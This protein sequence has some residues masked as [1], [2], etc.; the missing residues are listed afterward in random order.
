M[1]EN[2]EFSEKKDSIDLVIKGGTLL[3][4]VDGKVP[5]HAPWILIRDNRIIDILESSPEFPIPS[6]TEIIDAADSIILPG[7]I[8]AHSHT[9]MT[10]F[11]G[12]SDDLPLAQWLFD[13]IFPAEAK[14]L[15]PDSVYYGTLLGCLEMIA[16]GTTSVIDGYFFQ[17]STVKAFHKAGLRGLLAQ[18][19]IDFSAPGVE[20]PEKNLEIGRAFLDR[21][22]D[23]SSLITPGLF[24]HSTTT[25][26]EHT[27]KN[28]KD[29]CDDY[30]IP[31]Q[32]HLSETIQD[33]EQIREKTGLFPVNYLD[34][35]GIL[36]NQL[37]AVHSVHLNDEEIDIL[38]HKGVRVVHT[39]ESNM[40]LSS[41]GARIHDMIQKGI[42]M[43][44]GTDGCASN[45]N[46]DMFLEMDMAAK[47]GKII[48]MDPVS[49]DAETVLKM[50]TIWG[51]RVMGLENDIGS[52]EKGKKADI[53]IVDT[54]APHMV[55]LY[56][57][58]SNIVY[59]A[60]GADVKDVI[61]DGKILMRN[62][63]F[64]CLDQEEIME[65]VRI[66]GKD[67]AKGG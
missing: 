15:N 14:Y 24:C 18:G 63:K 4:M 39:P 51:A 52:I 3:T 12:Y 60:N 25:C 56:N 40:K 36:D 45:N 8:N 65:K 28:A 50:A 57:P 35:L 16:S 9:A 41:G 48:N 58:V 62:K 19:I 46:L 6:G 42:P 13:K 61:V 30:S 43:G 27:L 21:W 67:I 26:S 49:M 23:C 2:T 37:I 64:C 17:D 54:V 66:I 55:P 5:I 20:D 31:L 53:I 7:L 29:I 34:S 10:L 59:S 11:R 47:L 38:A 33:V 32:I 22:K 44:L 1:K